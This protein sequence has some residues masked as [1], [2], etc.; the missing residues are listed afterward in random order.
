MARA[1]ADY[2]TAQIAVAAARFDV[3][4]FPVRE[5]RTQTLN[6]LLLKYECH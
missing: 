6:G 4:Q 2:A 1:P 5:F 3:A